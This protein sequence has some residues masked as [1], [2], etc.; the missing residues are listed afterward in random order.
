MFFPLLPP[1]SRAVLGLRVHAELKMGEMLGLVASHDL[2]VLVNWLAKPLKMMQKL[3]KVAVMK[4]K[5]IVEGKGRPKQFRIPSSRDT[6][7]HILRKIRGGTN[8][9]GVALAQDGT[10]C[11]V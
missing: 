2:K 4:T 8:P 3:P 5:V 1:L 7:V 6:L 11:I 9:S 10:R